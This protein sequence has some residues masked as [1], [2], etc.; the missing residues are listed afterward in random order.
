MPSLRYRV[1]YH[2]L[3]YFK[4][5]GRAH[6]AADAHCD[7]HILD[8]AALALDQ[9]VTN[10]ARPGH[11]VGM[12]NGNGTAVDVETL[13]GNPQLIAAVDSLHGECLVEFPEPDVVHL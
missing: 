5:P 8:T 2:Q 6:A 10:Q 7:H 11:A 3:R 13:H 1:N 4:Q 9:R 12:A